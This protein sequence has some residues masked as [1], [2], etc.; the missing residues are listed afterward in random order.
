[1]GQAGVYSFLF[2]TMMTIREKAKRTIERYNMLCNGETVLVGVSGGPDSMALLYLLMD[3]R[4]EY[5]ITL[6]AAHL[7]HG[8]RKEAA[9]EAEFVRKTAA[10][11]GLPVIIR[12]ID[13]PAIKETDGLSAQEAAR[14]ARYAFFAEAAEEAGA[15][16]V[17][18]AHTADDQ[19]ETVLMRLLR[20]SG[21]LGLSG[22]PPVR[23]LTCS[24]L[25][26]PQSAI[27]NPQFLIIR[28]LIDCSRKEIEKYI[29]ER[30]IPFVTDI[31][32]L[33]MDYM[34]NRVRT[35]LLPFLEGYNPNIKETLVRTADVSHRDNQFLDM[36]ADRI[37]TT[38]ASHDMKGTVPDLRTERSEVVESG[39]SPVTVTMTFSDIKVLHP[40][41]SSRVI[42]KGIKAVKGDLKRVSFQHISDILSLIDSGEGRWSLHLPGVTVSREHD[43]LHFKRGEGRR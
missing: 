18:L 15:S 38:V 8:F 23:A 27:R 14:K 39:L 34:R 43:K 24:D 29:S 13:V 10:L 35:E 37:Y 2:I 30:N 25:E 19:A 12:S 28:P 5:G 33:K 11:L 26:I 31:S 20:G 41:V 17:A 22:I 3:I 32:N 1:M 16:M 4:N 42:R 40:A 21:P 36:E 9:D 6:K 7:N